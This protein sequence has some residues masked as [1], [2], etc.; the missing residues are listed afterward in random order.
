MA[1]IYHFGYCC[2]NHVSSSGAVGHS[3]GFIH[4]DSDRIFKPHPIDGLYNDANVRFDKYRSDCVEFFPKSRII[5]NPDG[6]IQ[7]DAVCWSFDVA[8][9]ADEY[10]E[11]GVV[12]A[13]GIQDVVIHRDDRVQ[14]V[15][16]CGLGD[17][18]IW[19]IGLVVIPIAGIV[20]H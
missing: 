10:D 13:D 7:Y 17:N 1:L 6:R 8:D 15:A 5:V 14:F 19:V 16:N 11:Y 3:I 18:T 20:I 9:C 4:D 12:V 2:F